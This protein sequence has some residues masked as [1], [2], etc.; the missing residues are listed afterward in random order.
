MLFRHRY[1]GGFAKA[2][3]VPVGSLAGRNFQIKENRPSESGVRV[4]IGL[5]LERFKSSGQTLRAI[6][7][8]LPESLRRTSW[9]FLIPPSIRLL[10]N[11]LRNWKEHTVDNLNQ[12]TFYLETYPTGLWTIVQK[13]LAS[14]TLSSVASVEKI[15]LKIAINS[16]ELRGLPRSFGMKVR[17]LLSL[18]LILTIF[19]SLKGEETCSLMLGDELD[20]DESVAILGK[21]ITFC[22][23]NCVRR[24]EENA[25]YYIKASPSLQKKFSVDEQKELGVDKVKLLKQRFCPVYKDRIVN[26]NSPSIEY[27]GEKIYFWSSTAV[28]RWNRD[29]DR[30]YK[31]AKND[32]IL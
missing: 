9:G 26:P 28:R 25:A 14:I 3:E 6:P 2:I 17:L 19:S 7:S 16:C 10:A 27:N 32:K 8:S 15:P 18:P 13:S 31:D 24:F 23:G 11:S 12:C 29:P 1:L 30:Y 4:G 21:T 5:N 20:R 22:C